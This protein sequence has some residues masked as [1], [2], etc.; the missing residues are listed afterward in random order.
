LFFEI[1]SIILHKSTYYLGIRRL[2]LPTHR[3]HYLAFAFLPTSPDGPTEPLGLVR[4]I[5]LKP[6]GHPRPR[7]CLRA[8][9]WRG[10]FIKFEEVEGE[11]EKNLEAAAGAAA[12]AH[13]AS[14]G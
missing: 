4:G 7:G 6:T 13:V 10:V 9:G 8:C 2:L 11:T 1:F 5:E 3:Q 12:E 14:S